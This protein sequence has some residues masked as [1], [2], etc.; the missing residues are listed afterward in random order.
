MYHFNHLSCFFITI[1]SFL[2]IASAADNSTDNSTAIRDGPGALALDYPFTD[3]A[4]NFAVN[5]T[6]EI[7]WDWGYAG[8]W[9]FGLIAGED[10][11]NNTGTWT[12]LPNFL[13]LKRS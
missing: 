5:D 12:D 6:I 11:I 7:V 10:G 2:T 4:N 8:N 3:R 9:T 1:C 13:S